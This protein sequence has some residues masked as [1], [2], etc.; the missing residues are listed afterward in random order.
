MVSPMVSSWKGIKGNDYDSDINDT[1]MKSN[2]VGLVLYF[3]NNV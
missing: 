2:L 1:Q 3:E